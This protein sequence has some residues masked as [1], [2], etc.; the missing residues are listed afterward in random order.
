MKN[1]RIL[2]FLLSAA[3]VL[4][5]PAYGVE[6]DAAS[7]VNSAAA[8]EFAVEA[9]ASA[10]C[11]EEFEVEI[12]VSSD[13]DEA[14]LLSSLNFAVDY[15]ENVL[16]LVS[17]EASDEVGDMGIAN[18]ANY[19]WFD[20]S[21]EGVEITSVPTA[22]AVATFKVLEG[23]NAGDTVITLSENST[24]AL[25]CKLFGVSDEV[26]PSVTADTVAIINNANVAIT[27]EP[28]VGGSV[29]AATALAPVGSTITASGNKLTVGTTVI[30][31]SADAKYDFTGWFINGAA[32]PA[33]GYAVT[34]NGDI[35]VTAKF[36]LGSASLTFAAD[37]NGS[38]D[39]TSATV[40]AGSSITVD[41]TKL[42][43]GTTVLA[44]AS[45]NSNYRF[46]GWYL[47]GVKV[48]ATVDIAKGG[49][50]AFTAK[51][52]HNVKNVTFAAGANGTVDKASAEVLIG[53]SVK[54]ESN[55]LTVGSLT[56]TAT[57]NP[58]YKFVGWFLGDAEY[59]GGTVAADGTYAFTAKFDKDTYKISV[60]SGVSVK[61]NGKD[62]VEGGNGV[63]VD[64]QMG[65]TVVIVPDSDVMVYEVL[66]N[67]TALK[68]ENGAFTVPADAITKTG[69][70]SVNKYDYEFVSADQYKALA[71][72]GHKIVMIDTD[73]NTADLTLEGSDFYYSSKY[74]AYVAII[75]AD[76]TALEIGQAITAKSGSETAIKYN[77]DVN[78]DGNVTA[79]DSAIAS[80]LLHAYNVSDTSYTDLMRFEA[81]VYG[82]YAEGSAYVTSADCAWMLYKAVGLEY[83]QN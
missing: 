48:T 38:V 79:A 54:V 78:G 12:T 40:N 74:S 70:V 60:P 34:N 65:D 32:I 44:T 61:V 5:V 42:M 20:I 30:T 58:G 7:G 68:A 24:T 27:V 31:A 57:A 17:V 51:F 16:T 63:T 14:Q 39:K 83:P 3:M 29:S 6:L 4:S 33:N 52:A 18:G 62:A 81:D 55:K 77:G 73:S 66:F 11:G 25:G 80:E 2:S 56:V 28:T 43:N 47:N 71:N 76:M 53:A 19:A 35:A 82:S 64:A 13:G 49:A 67:G 21:S 37:A 9:P 22:V 8:V 41:G 45:A 23:I 75:D 72:D 59:T 46:E 69:T 50:Y 10:E 1:K 36:T 15:D 26:V